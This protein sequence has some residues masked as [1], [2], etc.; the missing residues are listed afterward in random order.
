MKLLLNYSTRA[1]LKCET[2][3]VQCKSLQA[4]APSLQSFLHKLTGVLHQLSS[5]LGSFSEATGTTAV[6]R[7][8]CLRQAAALKDLTMNPGAPPLNRCLYLEMTFQ[9]SRLPPTSPG[10]RPGARRR[11][12]GTPSPA[13]GRAPP[14]RGS[15]PRGRRGP[16]DFQQLQRSHRPESPAAAPRPA[17]PA[18]AAARLVSDC[19]CRVRAGLPQAP[20][21][22]TREGPQPLYPTSSSGGYLIGI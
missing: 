1:K 12:A 2:K 15:N 14:P 9:S 8:H 22:T 16:P 11:R 17:R 13:A 3:R 4:L 20:L 19:G 10:R 18:S 7:S 5:F 6:P 21:V